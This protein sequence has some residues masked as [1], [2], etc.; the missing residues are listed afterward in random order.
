MH[1]ERHAW[2]AVVAVAIAAVAV[3]GCQ[4]LFPAFYPPPSVDDLSSF[5]PDFSEPPD[6]E[7]SPIATYTKGHATITLAD[8]TTV[9]LDRVGQH[10]GLST[11]IGLHVQWSNAAGWYLGLGGPGTSGG[12]FLDGN[13]P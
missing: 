2:R 9:E 6:V 11:D 4:L 7:P 13:G 10:S 3:S 1:V 8:G 12:P 5:E